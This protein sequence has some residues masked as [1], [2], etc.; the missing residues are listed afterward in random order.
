VNR[1][2]ILKPVDE[3]VQRRFEVAYKG[4]TVTVR[5]EKSY[6]PRAKMTT[7]NVMFTIYGT[8]HGMFG[9]RAHYRDYANVSKYFQDQPD[10]PLDALQ[11]FREV[12]PEYVNKLIPDSKQTRKRLTR[13]SRQEA[14]DTA[15]LNAARQAQCRERLIEA[16]NI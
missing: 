12:L 15:R 9:F 3:V 6:S 5:Y 7:E 16:G 10:M 13:R 14:D 2:K 8:K 4:K 1:S 11:M